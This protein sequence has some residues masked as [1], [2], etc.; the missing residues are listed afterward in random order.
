MGGQVSGSEGQGWG[1][2][3]EG[4]RRRPWSQARTWVAGRGPGSG[5]GD[6]VWGQGSD[7]I[8]GEDR[9]GGDEGQSWEQVGFRAS[10]EVGSG[11]RCGG[12]EGWSQEGE[13]QISGGGPEPEARVAIV[14][15]GA[16]GEGRGWVRRARSRVRSGRGVAVAGRGRGRGSRPG[17][18]D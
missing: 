15:R 11:V 17:L 12:G 7:R 2:R 14:G 5:L 13:G 1:V 6:P 3:E 4:L 8:G 16:R 18:G 9:E 10:G